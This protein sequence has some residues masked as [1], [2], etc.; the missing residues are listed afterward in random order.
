MGKGIQIRHFHTNPARSKECRGRPR[1]RWRRILV[2]LI[3][4]GRK[5]IVTSRKKHRTVREEFGNRLDVAKS[6]IVHP[7][8]RRT[9]LSSIRKQF[10]ELARLNASVKTLLRSPTKNRKEER[11]DEV[12]YSDR[13]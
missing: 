12:D 10:R 2:A 7:S 11:N 9:S 1:K 13:R 4:F 8:L 6:R 3:R 5:V